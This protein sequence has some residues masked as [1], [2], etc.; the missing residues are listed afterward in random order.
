MVKSALKILLVG[1]FSGRNIGDSAMTR[2]AICLLKRYSLIAL[3]PARPLT[4]PVK[5][6]LIENF[7]ILTGSRAPLL[8]CLHLCLFAP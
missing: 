1:V 2:S 6:S 4:P 7:S 5:C 3:L 8:F